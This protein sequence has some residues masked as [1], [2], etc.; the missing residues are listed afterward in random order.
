MFF[1]NP[2]VQTFSIKVLYYLD[3]LQLRKNS[4]SLEN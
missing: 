2:H 4:T 1:K 3:Y